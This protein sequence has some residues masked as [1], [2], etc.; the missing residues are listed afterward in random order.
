MVFDPQ[1]LVILLIM[2]AGSEP[3]HKKTRT[4]GLNRGPQSHHAV[5]EPLQKMQL[6]NQN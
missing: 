3:R 2:N 4:P 5:D 1:V 6:E